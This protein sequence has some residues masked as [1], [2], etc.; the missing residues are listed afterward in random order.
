MGQKNRIQDASKCVHCHLCQKNCVFLKKYGIDIKDTDRLS[1][2]A[3][4]C[5]L[6]GRCTEV[7]PAGIDG[8][9]VIMDMRRRHVAGDG[10][11][12]VS[13]RYKRTVSEKQDYLYRNY[14]HG[15]KKRVLFPGCNF[16]S[17]YPKT[18]KT[19]VKLLEEQA[20][21]GVIYECCGKPIA[22][23]GMEQ[24][25]KAVIQGIEKR[26]K[27]R[28]VEELILLCPNCYEYLKPRISLK[29]T[30]IYEVLTE[31]GIGF[32]AAG[33]ARMFRPCPDR[34]KGEW[35][36]SITPFL[37]KPCEP[38]TEIQCCGLGGCAGV[39]EP[40]LSKGFARKLK[41]IPETIYTY[42][43]SCAG[44]LTRNG[45]RQVRHILPEILGIPEKPDTVKSLINRMKTKYL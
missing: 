12:F 20:G 23:L 17:V 16:P 34:E 4:H 22:D 25:E 15:T 43:G 45:C 5:F 13:R 10:G 3:Y 30:N 32:K 21:I 35:L 33:G 37:E 14:K 2:L 9:G 27:E 24:Q 38:V 40:E 31:L 41:N 26:L 39:E 29:V 42:C 19:L 36:A 18:T 44:Q 11:A 1:E 6:C 8:R 28:H 7:C